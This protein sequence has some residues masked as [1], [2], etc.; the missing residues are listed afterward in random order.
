MLCILGPHGPALSYQCKSK[1]H[2]SQAAA[3]HEGH[4]HLSLVPF[5]LLG[6]LIWRRQ[7]TEMFAFG[8]KAAAFHF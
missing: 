2:L 6:L 7:M 3:I 5:Y 8:S 1:E 4:L